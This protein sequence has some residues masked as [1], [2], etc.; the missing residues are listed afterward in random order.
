[1]KILLH[2]S[3]VY[4]CQFFLVSSALLGPCHSVLYLAHPCINCSF[5]ISNSLKERDLVFFHSIIFL[6]FFASFTSEGFLISPSYSLELNIQLGIPFPFSFAFHISFSLNKSSVNP[7]A[8]LHFFLFFFWYSFGHCLLYNVMN[9]CTY[10]FRHSIYQIISLE[11][12]CHF[13]CIIIRDLI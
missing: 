8:F 5:G 1:M 9:L 13:H 2:S 11:S 4:S 7:F 12:I 6:Y 10:F 3:S